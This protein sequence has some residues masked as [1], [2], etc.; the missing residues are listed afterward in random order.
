MF[1]EFRYAKPD[2]IVCYY[3]IILSCMVRH[4]VKRLRPLFVGGAMQIPFD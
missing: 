3:I 1:T 4:I 2:F